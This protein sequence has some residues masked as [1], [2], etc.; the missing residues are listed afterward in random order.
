MEIS[1]RYPKSRRIL[2]YVKYDKN[3][4]NIAGLALRFVKN[5]EFS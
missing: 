4:T 3:L 2:I 1:A 5:K